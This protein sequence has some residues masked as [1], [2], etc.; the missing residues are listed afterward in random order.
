MPHGGI[1]PPAQSHS[2]FEAS[3]LP[4]SHHGWIEMCLINLLY[5]ECPSKP[6]N[7]Q[8]LKCPEL[9]WNLILDPNSDIYSIVF[10]T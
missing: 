5:F 2:L 10:V 4:P 8:H 7:F 3:A 1:D 6:G 9:E